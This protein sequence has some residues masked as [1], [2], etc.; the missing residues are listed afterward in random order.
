MSAS[1]SALPPY[2]LALGSL[3]FA[4]FLA[5]ADPPQVNSKAAPERS[6]RL[7]VGV[8]VIVRQEEDYH[9]VTNYQ[10]NRVQ[11]DGTMIP[12]HA[13]DDLRFN[14]STKLSRNPLT[15]TNLK[16]KRV[17]GTQLQT[18]E[19]MRNQ[20]ALDDYI[21]KESVRLQGELQASMEAATG[22]GAD[23]ATD[24]PAGLGVMQAQQDISSF[25][26][27]ADTATDLTLEADQGGR[28]SGLRDALSVTATV[29]SPVPISNAYVIGLAT[30]LTENRGPQDVIFMHRI[31]KL[32]PRPRTFSTLKEGLPPNF[33]IKEIKLH[34]YR[35]GEELVSDQSAKQFALT[36]EEALEYLVLDHSS[37]HRR[38]T[39]PA[40]PV[41]SLAPPALLATERSD[42]YNYP[43]S[44]EVD[45]TGRVAAFDSKMIIPDRVKEIVQDMFFLPALQN[46]RPVAGTTN[47]N[48]QDYFK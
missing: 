11:A 2:V 48:L 24:A 22:G 25:Q 40:K 17:E 4:S 8:D 46:G 30:I 36:R 43:V 13:V 45:A 7:F 27:F 26:D 15:I 35:N 32:G 42:R 18:L 16:S 9:K 20:A 31:G 29:S 47:I 1:F 3:G 28:G 23:A 38:E 6:Y 37:R 12:L 14:F 34:I 5:A 44:V 10:N 21:A 41:W 33:E 39:L 19:A